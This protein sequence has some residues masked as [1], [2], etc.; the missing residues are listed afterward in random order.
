MNTEYA[1]LVWSRRAIGNGA[2]TRYET[3][4][5]APDGR[6]VT[7]SSYDSELEAE[8]GLQWLAGRQV[9][10]HQRHQQMQQ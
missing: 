1:P 5:Y 4:F 2:E 6:W 8:D 9:A 10:A 3:G 7:H